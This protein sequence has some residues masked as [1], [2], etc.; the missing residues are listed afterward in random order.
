MS[1]LISKI[2]LEH[3][4][5]IKFRCSSNIKSKGFTLLMFLVM[6]THKYPELNNE[7]EKYRDTIDKKNELGWTALILASRNSNG[8][9]NVETIKLL[10]GKG[11]NKYIKNNDEN[12]TQDLQ[13]EIETMNLLKSHRHKINKGSYYLQ[14]GCTKKNMIYI[15]VLNE[16]YDK[17]LNKDMINEI[18]EHLYE[19]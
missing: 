15:N 3:I 19:E 13:L 9:S 12:T 7:I 10:L 1:D 11:A 17:V 2:F 4:K 5:N 14:N 16:R 18:Y 8:D 6:N